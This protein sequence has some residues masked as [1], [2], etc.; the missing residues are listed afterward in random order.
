MSAF[1]PHLPPDFEAFWE[2]TFGSAEE[3]PLD[4]VRH[5]EAAAEHSTS[6]HRVETFTFR[7]ISGAERHGWI[8]VPTDAEPPFPAFL[9][10]PPYGRESLLPNAYGTRKGFLSLSLNFFGHGAFHQEKY[11]PERGYF[12]EGVDQPQT[13]IF[14]QMAQDAAIALRVL[15]NLQ[16]VDAFRLATM[17]MSQGAGISIW[18]GACQDRVRAVCADMP[19][20]GGM[21]AALGRQVYRYPLKELIDHAKTTPLGMESVLRT[22]SYFDTMHLATHCRKPTHVSLGEKDPA[23]KPENVEAIYQALPGEKTLRRY[24][25]GH[26]WF[27]DM[28][29]NNREWL[30]RHLS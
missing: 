6:D 29:D 2:E 1:E 4:Y 5:G 15:A 16:E 10:I 19:F 14:R 12:A 7:G 17:G 21:R 9:W 23:A 18:L 28:I 8:A 26:D 11:T 27:P 13:W 25:I 30:L 3:A 24:P 20:L 22:L